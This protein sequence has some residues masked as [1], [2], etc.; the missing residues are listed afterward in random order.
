M[1]IFDLFCIMRLQFVEEINTHNNIAIIC[2]STITI[3]III[4]LY[5]KTN[6]Y[7][8]FWNLYYRGNLYYYKI[9][10][11]IDVYTSTIVALTSLLTYS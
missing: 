10:R 7:N 6:E 2:R 9:A 4:G 8:C 3:I 1:R 5:N 11:I